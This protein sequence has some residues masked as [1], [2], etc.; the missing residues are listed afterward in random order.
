MISHSLLATIY[1]INFQ[2]IITVNDRS[3][4]LVV[5]LQQFDPNL[6]LQIWQHCQFIT[7]LSLLCEWLVQP[8][9]HGKLLQMN[10]MIS[11]SLLTNDQFDHIYNMVGSALFLQ[12]AL[13]RVHCTNTMHFRRPSFAITPTVLV[14]TV[15]RYFVIYAAMEYA[16]FYWNSFISLPLI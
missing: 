15:N 13:Y 4:T 16:T 6:V 8:T 2:V 1:C 9:I 7:S 12:R 3:Y 10:E 14:S 5:Y 11:Q